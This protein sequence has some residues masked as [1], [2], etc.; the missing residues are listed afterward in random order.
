MIDDD[1]K[2][3]DLL[4]GCLKNDQYAWGRFGQFYG[5]LMRQVLR[6][7]R[8]KEEE[9]GDILQE[10]FFKLSRGSLQKF[11]GGTRYEFY[12]YLKTIT[13]HEAMD[14][15]S[16]I[17]RRKEVSEEDDPT[18]IP[19]TVGGPEE[20][21]VATEKAELLLMRFSRYPMLDQEIFKM[22]IDGNTYKEVGAILGMP[23]RTVAFRYT[24]VRDDFQ[25]FLQAN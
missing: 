12:K 16:A 18:G 13:I 1:K 19:G 4:D 24:K 2:L 6:A 8:I 10:V 21:T 23:L 5:K 11:Q 3:R 14:F 25:R 7:K 15:F 9:I 17:K 22:V 20:I